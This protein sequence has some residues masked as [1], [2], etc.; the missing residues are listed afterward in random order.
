MHRIYRPVWLIFDTTMLQV[1]RP[2][3]VTILKT[4]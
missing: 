4:T 2:Q 3:W 1:A